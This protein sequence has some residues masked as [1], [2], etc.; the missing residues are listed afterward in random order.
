MCALSGLWIYKFS[1]VDGKDWRRPE[2]GSFRW[3]SDKIRAL[4]KQRHVEERRH[5][6]QCGAKTRR[7]G[8]K[9]INLVSHRHFYPLPPG[10][11]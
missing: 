6:H 1:E 9:E 5:P 10:P 3:V 7:K 8:G 4:W 2:G 11:R